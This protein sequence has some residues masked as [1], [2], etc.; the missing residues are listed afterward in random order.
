MA[1]RLASASELT[2]LAAATQ[3]PHKKPISSD[4]FNILTTF[5]AFLSGVTN[6]TMGYSPF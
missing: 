3:D 2:V 6:E 1:S 5:S 4:A